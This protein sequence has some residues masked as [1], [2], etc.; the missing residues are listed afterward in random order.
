MEIYYLQ[1]LFEKY[2]RNECS[3]EEKRELM[4]FIE[5]P[6][7]EEVLKGLIDDYIANSDTEEELNP[8]KANLILRRILRRNDAAPVSLASKK[9]GPGFLFRAA[10]ILLFTAIGV[11][12][13]KYY[14]SS[15]QHAEQPSAALIQK[16]K[17]AVIPGGNHATLRRS[18]GTLFLLDSL[19][20][21]SISEGSI[22]IEKRDGMLIYSLSEDKNLKTDQVVYNTLTTPAGGQY[23]VLLPDGSKVWLNAASSLYFPSAFKG[24]T[25]EV[26]IQGEAYFEVAH[27]THR[28]FDVK[29]EGMVVRVL[30]THFN[31]NAYKDDSNIRTSLLEG[32]IRI[33]T[34][35]ISKLLE[36]GQ[37]GILKTGDGALDV[38]D[39]DM[40]Q[41]IAWKN[42]LFDFTGSDFYTIMHQ[43]GRWYNV[44]IEF[45]G[46]IPRRDFEGKI[47]RKAQLSEILQILEL[48]NLKFE[49]NGKKI[50]VKN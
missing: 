43:I 33:K 18:N 48:Q 2:I 39:A 31:I 27:D 15:D 37:Q 46:E 12:F 49:V 21:G 50:V 10:A 23:Q 28:P 35:N 32:S 40:N 5:Q 7:N 24:N 19:K 42:G 34:G 4:A 41:V 11:Y 47:S 16:A 36:P 17:D 6:Q 14:Q 29:V 3:N 13:W 44:D 9:N 26:S 30:G 25:R 38:K 45:A 20:D 8:E 22:H 1:K